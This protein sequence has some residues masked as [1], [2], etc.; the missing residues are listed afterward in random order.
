MFDKNKVKQ[1]FLE[2][3]YKEI[4]SVF[5]KEYKQMVIDFAKRNDMQIDDMKFE[6]LLFTIPIEY[7]Y[8]EGCIDC[9]SGIL[10]SEDMTIYE[11]I[12]EMLNCYND[13]KNM[14]T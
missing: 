2:K 5:K 9:I 1:L 10:F 12:D 13:T 8:L 3:K 6:D 11:N 4:Y 7:P 14:L